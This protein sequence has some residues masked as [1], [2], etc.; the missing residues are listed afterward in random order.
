[1]GGK[2]LGNDRIKRGKKDGDLVKKGFD[3]LGVTTR[4]WP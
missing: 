2:G 1:M 3:N 4:K